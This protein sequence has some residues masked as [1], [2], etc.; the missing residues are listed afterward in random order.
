MLRDLEKIMVKG[1][2][3]GVE[4]SAVGNPTMVCSAMDYYRSP[5]GNR[6]VG[7]NRGTEFGEKGNGR[8]NKTFPPHQEYVRKLTYART[9]KIY[10]N[11]DGILRSQ[12]TLWRASL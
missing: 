2:S 12:L 4:F 3:Q 1:T 5:K 9:S 11:S 10:L 6:R 7:T 8:W